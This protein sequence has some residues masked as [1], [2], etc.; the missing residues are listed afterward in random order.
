MVK[1]S[2]V[3]NLCIAEP[4]TPGW[5]LSAHLMTLGIN[6]SWGERKNKAW[7]TR[8]TLVSHNGFE[9]ET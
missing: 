6:V 7:N 5:K 1:W 8:Y 9:V 4:P 3:K 2:R